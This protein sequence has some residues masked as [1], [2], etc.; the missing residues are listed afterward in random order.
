MNRT[1]SASHVAF[2]Y[3]SNYSPQVDGS[4]REHIDGWFPCGNASSTTWLVESTFGEFD[5]SQDAMAAWVS[6]RASNK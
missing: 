2:A 4:L 6:E 5:A 3:M 1:A